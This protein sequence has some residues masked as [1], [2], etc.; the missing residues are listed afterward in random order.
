MK[1]YYMTGAGSLASHIAL[2]WAAACYE[3]VRMTRSRLQT[4][5]FLALSP[6]GTVPVLLHDDLCLTES[7]AILAHIADVYPAAGLWGGSGW[8]ARARALQGL[9]FLNSEV[10]KAFAPIF[11]PERFRFGE[12]SA[13]DVS[14]AARARVRALFTRIERQMAGRSWLTG[15]RS[16]ADAYL[17]VMLRWALT[18]KIG[19]AGF[20][21]LAAFLRRLHDDRG[22]RAALAVEERLAGAPMPGRGEVSLPSPG[23]G[24]LLAEIVGIVQYREGEGV[25]QEVRRG[26]VEIAIGQTDVVI[27]WRDEQY[28]GQAAMPIELFTSYVSGGAIRI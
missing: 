23:A 18:T 14:A 25:P 22:I 5:E 2:E 4:P 13:E 6:M 24:S 17:F 21:E 15:E 12:A 26:A 7:V 16:I 10:H 3:A 19:L 11:Y 8:S 20:P 27:S 9:A 28:H 1:L